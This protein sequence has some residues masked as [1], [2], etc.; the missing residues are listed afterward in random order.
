MSLS[1]NDVLERLQRSCDRLD[2]QKA[3]AEKHNVSTA[4]VCDVLQHRRDPG[5]SILEA[6]GLVAVTVYAKQTGPRLKNS[7]VLSK[8]RIEFEAT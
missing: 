8:I 1:I 4:Y 7:A 5:P 3:W 2:S 6:L